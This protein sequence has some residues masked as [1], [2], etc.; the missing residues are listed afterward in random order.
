MTG[1]PR[2]FD[3]DTA[4]QSAVDAFWRRGYEATSVADLVAATGVN[5]ASMY[6]TF[7]N[8]RELFIEVQNLLNTEINPMVASHGGFIEVERWHPGASGARAPGSAGQSRALPRDRPGP[9]V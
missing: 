3:R 5:R 2:E 1:R 4:L 8:K 7:G 9:D 6:D